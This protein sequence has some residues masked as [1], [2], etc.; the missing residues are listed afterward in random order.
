M[1]SLDIA[2]LLGAVVILLA[3]GAARLGSRLG[4]PALLL[5]LVLGMAL[6]QTL[7]G[8]GF[9]N[10]E[11]AHD[12]GF[13]ALAVI[14]AEGG[15]TTKWDD[16]KPVL[17][18]AGLLAT[19]GVVLSIGLVGL[20]GYFVLGLPRSVAFLVG[21]VT[22]PTDSAAVF[23]VLRSVPLPHRLRAV[24]EGESGLN[25]AP[26]VLLVAAGTEFALGIS[27]RGGIPGLV[28]LVV[29]ELVGGI[30]VGL[31]VGWVGVQFLRRV[32]LPAAGLYPLAVMAWTL[33]AYGL[34]VVGHVSAFAAV[35]VCAMVLGNARLPHRHP[36]RSF[37]EGLGWVAQI[38]LF[39]M[40]GMLATP[41]RIDSVAVRDGVLVGVFLTFVVRPIAVVACAVWFRMPWRQQAFLSWAGLRGAVPIILATV[42]LVASIPQSGLLFDLVVVFVVVFTALQAP[43]LGWV[44]RRLGLVDPLAATDADV[45]VAPLEH[46][47]A[48]LLRITV[49]PHSRLA[50]VTIRE[51]RL[52]PNAV[53][54][55]IIRDGGSFSPDGHTALQARDAL[56]IVTPAQH[57]AAV[58]DR[59][60]QIGR[61][62]RLAH[63]RGIRVGEAAPDLGVEQ[64][65]E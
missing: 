18:L 10:A 25:D 6:G 16:I 55:L 14:L 54:A 19:V 51:L 33:T 11:L 4:M 31:F 43:T 63:W 37:A 59:L 15:L 44:A 8:Y 36:T 48:D 60:T 56:L 58:E 23:S 29:V 52:P 47:D 32:A 24:L 9:Q 57:R 7:P 30:L 20:F 17:G 64:S 62:G 21:A 26:T 3:I 2:V 39:I 22:A 5:F 34:S 41:E 12:L 13:I 40:L 65:D 49:P 53:V 45:E 35:Y 38:G 42:P 61:G 1:P 50:G 46:E 28:G 27:P